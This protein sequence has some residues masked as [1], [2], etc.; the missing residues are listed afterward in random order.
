MVDDT[1]ARYCTDLQLASVTTVGGET[2]GVRVVATTAGFVVVFRDVST[3]TTLKAFVVDTTSAS[4]I[5][6]S[7]AAS[8]TTLGTDMELS[9]GATG[10]P[11]FDAQANA[12]YGAFVAYRTT[13][14]APDQIKFGFVN[15]AGAGWVCHSDSIAATFI[16]W[17]ADAV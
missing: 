13:A 16:F 1:G 10:Y 2:S 3:A 4:T 5:A 6:T 8:P 7:L 11:V 14:V 17:F 12:V 15:A 9:L